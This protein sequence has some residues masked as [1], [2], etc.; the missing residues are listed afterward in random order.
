MYSFN[1]RSKSGIERFLAKSILIRSI[2]LNKNGRHIGDI[3]R[4]PQGT[5]YGRMFY[6][7]VRN[8][9]HFYRKGSGY[10]VDKPML[11][12][13]VEEELDNYRKITGDFKAKIRVLV[14]YVGKT[15]S[16]LLVIE[17]DRFFEWNEELA[18]TKDTGENIETYGN[19]LS[20]PESEFITW[21]EESICS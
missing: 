15:V 8:P 5:E 4:F 16:K 9:E 20:L 19:Q 12:R 21:M 2:Q 18:Y 10:A 3:R 13:L 11:K 14:W 7:T 6:I 1:P 17:P